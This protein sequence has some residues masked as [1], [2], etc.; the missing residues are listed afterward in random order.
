MCLGMFVDLFEVLEG[1][2]TGAHTVLDC[3]VGVII[4]ELMK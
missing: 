2:R 4:Y 1:F 3:P